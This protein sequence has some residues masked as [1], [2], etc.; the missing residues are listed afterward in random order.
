MSRSRWVRIFAILVLLGL[1]A[2]QIKKQHDDRRADPGLAFGR[3]GLPAS[4]VPDNDTGGKVPGDP[5]TTVREG[6]RLFHSLDMYKQMHGAF[7]QDG[8]AFTGEMVNSPTMYGFADN[9]AAWQSLQSPDS[10]FADIPQWR[11]S[12]T[13]VVWIVTDQRPDG[14]PVGAP[15][16]SGAMDVVAYTPLY[17]HAQVRHFNGSKDTMKPTG[18]YIVV[19]ENGQVQKIPY[20]AVRFQR[21]SGHSSWRMGF[22]GQAGLSSDSISFDQMYHGVP[23]Q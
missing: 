13:S 4:G 22:P 15:K 6:Q 7:P 2:F 9:K 10:K 5:D 19:W 8:V 21:V 17:M 14:Q 18:F 20:N 16:A 3:T 12:P 11:Q 1:I 23:R